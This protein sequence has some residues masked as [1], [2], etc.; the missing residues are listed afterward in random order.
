MN[1]LKL[2]NFLQWVDCKLY[3]SPPLALLRSRSHPWSSPS[4][5]TCPRS[6]PLPQLSSLALF[7]GWQSMITFWRRNHRKQTKNPHSTDHLGQ[8]SRRVVDCRVDGWACGRGHQPGKSQLLDNYQE[9]S[10]SSYADTFWSKGVLVNFY[11]FGFDGVHTQIHFGKNKSC[12]IKGILP[13][14]GTAGE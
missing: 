14:C 6:T 9:F 2:W 7:P 10:W 8:I 11:I 13:T 4:P 1:R 12:K 3:L 5:A